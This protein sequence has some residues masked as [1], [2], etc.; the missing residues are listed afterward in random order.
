MPNYGEF[1]KV[2]RKAKRLTLREVEELTGISN[3]YLS[4]LESGK[5]KQP[6]PINLNKLGEAYDIPYEVLMEKAGYPV[7]NAKPFKGLPKGQIASRFG[8]LTDEEEQ[9]LLEY[10]SFLRTRKGKRSTK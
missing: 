2:A 6:S 8:P 3:A 4:Q 7:P 9:E 10:L 1:L 5:V